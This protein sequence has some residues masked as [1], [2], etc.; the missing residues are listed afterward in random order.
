[1]GSNPAP[2]AN[3]YYKLPQANSFSNVVDANVGS[4]QQDVSKQIGLEAPTLGNPGANSDGSFVYNS[5][6]N[7]TY[8]K[9]LHPTDV[10]AGFY[11]VNCNININQIIYDESACPI[12]PYSTAEKLS[13]YS[14]LQAQIN[15]IKQVIDNGN[16]EAMLQFIATGLGY[17]P[18]TLPEELRN[19]LSDEVLLFYIDNAPANTWNEFK[20]IMLYNSPLNAG[21]LEVF[22]LNNNIPSAIKAMV[23]AAQTGINP[24]AEIDK[25]LSF[26]TAEKNNVMHSI[27]SDMLEEGK[28][29]EAYIFLTDDRCL[30]SYILSIPIG[31]Q[32][33]YNLQSNFNFLE[34]EAQLNER[35][36][37][38][39]TQLNAVND[40]IDYYQKVITNR[41]ELGVKRNE[42]TTLFETSSYNSD[43]NKEQM[44]ESFGLQKASHTPKT[45]NINTSFRLANTATQQNILESK[46]NVLENSEITILPN[47]TS[48]NFRI[49]TSKN[50]DIVSIIDALGHVVIQIEN[51]QSNSNINTN[52]LSSG[53]YIIKIN[54]NN[55]INHKR[56]VISK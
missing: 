2:N 16:T 38:N 15:S 21:V 18:S 51:Y 42:L 47:P 12:L 13:N 26:Y 36:T 7:D 53:L 45:I 46:F 14:A 35:A 11:N 40:F 3:D 23:N 25:Q 4:T 48:N 54:S 56:L 39:E 5:F 9:T 17:D 8:Y 43:A 29:A 27:V 44:F 6:S 1:M 10:S 32:L 37:G 28:L 30:D 20:N 31:I 41:S 52:A 24:R 55:S 49:S 22:N 34:K 33:G 19:K 50:L